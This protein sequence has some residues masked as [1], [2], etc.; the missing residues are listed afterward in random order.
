M[1]VAS[2]PAAPDAAPCGSADYA[3]WLGVPQAQDASESI[4]A[5]QGALV[6]WLIMDHYALD[7]EWE[8]RLRPHVERLMVI[9]DLANR[10]HDCDLLLDQNL[11]PENHARYRNLVPS[12]CRLLLGPR[13]ALLGPEYR[14]WR[15]SLRPREGQVGRVLVFLGGSDPENVSYE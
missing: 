13:Y 7:A 4:E 12:T 3:A 14:V 11:V 10:S 15:R 8:R 6:D 9:D 1:P 5:I 2:L